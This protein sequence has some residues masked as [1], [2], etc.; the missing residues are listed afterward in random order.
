[1]NGL[2]VIIPSKNA[3]NLRACVEAVRK[4]EPGV[5]IFVID[6][7]V[8][9]NEWECV[10][11]VNEDLARRGI[12]LIDGVKPFCFA[13]NCNIGIHAAGEDDVV[14]LNDD[15]MLETP[16]GFTRM[17]NS[18]YQ[19]QTVGLMSSSTNVAGNPEQARRNGVAP[20]ILAG[21]TP[22]NS[23]PTVAFV[24]VLI[25]RSTI[26]LVGLLDERFGGIGPDGKP[27]YGYDDN[28]YCRRLELAGLRIGVHDG[29]FVDH[30]K[31]KSSF[32]GEPRAAGAI[33]EGRRIY[34]D[35]WGAM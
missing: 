20:R 1:V 22:G 29:C 4:N 7:G 5:R 17:Q 19:F 27:I 26:N 32:R 9:F 21:K 25:P 35:K 14:L 28:D 16:G 11:L 15:A 33:D 13:R 24:C 30:S 18:L 8:D 3:T 10:G 2:S 23:F 12:V 6:D 31:L 34:M